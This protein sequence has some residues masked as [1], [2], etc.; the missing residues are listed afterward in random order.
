[1]SS[2]EIND[3]AYQSLIDQ[4]NI[5]SK[6]TLCVK[7]T[8]E[9]KTFTAISQIS[10]EIEQDDD[11]G[12]SIHMVFTMNTLLGGRQFSS[13]LQSIEAQYGKGSVVIFASKY[14]GEY[15]HVRKPIELCGL[16][17]D[18][19][20]CPRVIVMCSNSRR[21]GDGVKFIEQLNRNNTPIKRVYAYYDELHKYI[22]DNL[23]EQIE[24]IHSFD[25][26]KSIIAL[27]ATPDPIFRSSGFWSQIRLIYLDNL[28]DADYIGFHQMLHTHIDDCFE[29]PYIRPGPFDFDGLDA[30]TL[31]FIR[32]TLE[33]HSN[34]LSNGSRSFIPAHIRRIGHD[35]VRNL[36]FEMNS[37]A[38]VVVLNGKE[39][40]IRWMDG[41]AF[42]TAEVL[43]PIGSSEEVC[44]TISRVVK[45]Y[46]LQSKP[47]VITG[48]L[49]VGMGQTLTHRSLGSFTSA[50]FGHMD[51]TNS[52]LYQLFGR[53]TGRMRGWDTY[54]P[55]VVYCPT[56][57]WNRCRVME[58]C[59]RL[60]ATGH[61]GEIVTEE[62][63]LEPMHTMGE[64]GQD[65]IDNLRK[66][67]EKKAR[68]PR[69]RASEDDKDC[70]VFDTQ[71][72]AIEFAKT[73]LG[74]RMNRR[75][76]P[77]AP[78]ELLDSNGQNPTEAELFKR[79]WGI[80]A[81]N[82]A[83]MI[84]TDQNKWC[85]Y[86]RPSLVAAAVASAEAEPSVAMIGGGGGGGGGGGEDV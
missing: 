14:D 68:L 37:N 79:M 15:A 49:C 7:R 76:L 72:E 30:D 85:V 56:I 82:T 3:V 70:R 62:Q 32:H 61:N 83:R 57:V 80:N 78:K 31:K 69:V 71:E 29:V 13:R 2:R 47:L 5:S 55:T 25:I 74:H 75:K 50:I 77:E 53:I 26:I 67:K 8:Q 16:C 20:T 54:V 33:N 59:A 22:S 4:E 66:K 35:Q 65:A 43:S 84:P 52:E 86:W 28:N 24:E 11:F 40:T 6:F 38:A 41:S 23:R 21:Y 81:K 19:H 60:I 1:M 64:V 44:E 36:V 63:Y 48:F 9:G 45:L 73:E 12:R 10:K 18:E 34:I 42:R 51:L 58:Q 27:T 17:F 46:N 39:K